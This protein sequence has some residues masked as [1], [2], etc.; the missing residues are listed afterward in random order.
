LA[1]WDAIDQQL[2]EIDDALQAIVR[3]DHRFAVL[4]T[5]PEVAERTAAILIAEIG[6][7]ANYESPR[8]VLKMAG[9]GLARSQSGTTILG[10]VRITKRG[11]PALRREL[12]MLAGRCCKPAGILR[13]RHEAMLA[14]NGKRRIKAIT[15][16][17]RGLVPLVFHILKTGEAFDLARWQHDHK[18]ASADVTQT[19]R[20]TSARD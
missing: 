12:F 11:R 9:L 20:R 6:D 19:T 7:V 10:P 2:A 13:A 15:A 5:I 16:L 3:A 4:L 1:R 14:R 17:S 18:P 8:Q